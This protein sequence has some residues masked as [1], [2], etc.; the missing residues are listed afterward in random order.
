MFG[1]SGIMDD[2]G[3]DGVCVGIID[4]VFFRG[5]VCLVVVWE[6]E[7]SFCRNLELL[8]L[9]C[10]APIL[11]LYSSYCVGTFLLDADNDSA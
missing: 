2:R 11:I 6:Q 4:R 1:D 10:I 5:S 8:L 3:F 7:G 9:C